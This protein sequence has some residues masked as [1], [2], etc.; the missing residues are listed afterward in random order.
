MSSHLS[1]PQTKEIFFDS[2]GKLFKHIGR[3][4]I[5]SETIALIEIVKN[6]YDAD[7]TE[8]L[9]TFDKVN[10]HNGEIIVTDNG[11]GMTHSQFEEFWM[12]PG[13]AHKEKEHT[14]PFYGRTMLGRKGMGRFGTDKIGAKVVVK[15]KTKVEPIAFAA[16]IDADEFEKP[17][18]KFQNT[19]ILINFLPRQEIKFVEKDYEFGTQIRM[20]KLRRT[21]SSKMIGEVREELCL[22]ITPDERSSNFNIIFDVKD[23]VSLSGKLENSI[24]DGFSHELIIEVDEND[25][26]VIKIDSRKI[27]DGNVLDD[28]LDNITA[29]NNEFESNHEIQESFKSFGPISGRILY[30]DKGGLKSHSSSKHGRR[31]DHTGV[32]LYRSGFIVKPY[33]EK[34]NDWL[35]LKAKRNTKGWRYYIN[36][37]KIMGYI[38]IDPQKNPK[39]EDTTNRQG[40]IDNDEKKTFEYFFSEIVIEELNKVLEKEAT[41]QKE[42][43]LKKRHQKITRQAAEILSSL[44]SEEIKK[45]ANE[46]NKRKKIETE[47][48]V[49]DSKISNNGK[50]GLRK[51][52]EQNE[53]NQTQKTNGE[54]RGEYQ[55]HQ[56]ELEKTDRFVVRSM[57]AWIDGTRWRIRPVDEPNELAEAWVNADEQ[58]I[59]YNVGHPMFKAAEQS[60]KTIGK[61]VE[62]GSGIAVQMHIHKSIA[63]AWGLFHDEKLK[64]SFFE[65][66][67]E[68]VQLAAKKIKEESSKFI[69]ET[70]EEDLEEIIEEN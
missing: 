9:I 38:N 66:Y 7:A 36:A 4:Q 35:R 43:N 8:V 14:S 1:Q 17:N 21:W 51:T 20:K 70:P 18:A 50:R 25:N 23:D 59:I 57:D 40:L 60:D 6:S 41:T 68:Y 45:V 53:E 15:S 67:N 48:L 26:Y 11:H 62:S 12:C 37:D 13:T 44:R 47:K 2:D 58:E 22:M 61:E 55:K 29:S 46:N 32:K 65:R 30:F 31:A 33:G 69:E 19:P 5:D 10:K 28:C 49:L 64:G 16:T 27:K 24:K 34:N 54:K 39:L 42:A 63:V 56:R 52:H 3:N